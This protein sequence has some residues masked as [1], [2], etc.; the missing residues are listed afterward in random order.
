M[1]P[2]GLKQILLF[3]ISNSGIN[4]NILSHLVLIGVGIGSA[5]TLGETENASLSRNSTRIT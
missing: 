5:F 3:T 1:Q 2:I 4:K